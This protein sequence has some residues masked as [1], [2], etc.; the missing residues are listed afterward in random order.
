M[1]SV[2]CC[3]SYNPT[4]SLMDCSAGHSC[5]VGERVGWNK[6]ARQYGNGL[7]ELCKSDCCSETR[8]SDCGVFRS[9]GNA[10]CGRWR[11]SALIDS[12][13]T[14]FDVD[15]GDDAIAS[16]LELRR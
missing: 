4:A 13:R 12:C 7:Q 1:D 16:R 15:L 2:D 14:I 5:S 3:S 8:S 6:L 9:E 11:E 10:R